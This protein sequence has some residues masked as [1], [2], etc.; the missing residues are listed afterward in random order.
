[1]SVKPSGARDHRIDTLRGL[2]LVSIFINHVPGN[3]LEPLTH[4]NFGLSDSA[5]LFV[6]LAGIAAAFAYLPGFAAGRWLL[7]SLK[8]V[9]RAAVLYVA[10]LA[11]TLVGLGIF[12][13][14][15]LAFGA[16]ELLAMVNI[17]PL[18]D[19]PVAGLAGLA[20]MTHQLGYH[21]ILP[22]YV[23]MLLMLPALLALAVLDLRLML[24]GSI[25]L[26]ALAQVFG[27]TMPSFPNEG[28]W[29]FNPFAWQLIFTIGIFVGARA[30]R[31]ETP[32]AYRPWLW[33]T[34]LA[35][36]AAALVYH[37]WNFYGSIPNLP[38]LP[39]HFQINEKPWVAAPRLAHLL[40]LAYVVGHSPVMRWLHRISPANPLPLLGRH[41][42]P[43]FWFGTALSMIGLIT[44]QIAAPGA[45][46]QVALLSTG[47]S[48]QVAL[49]F[50][51]EWTAAA[52]RRRRLPAAAETTT[53]RPPVGAVP[54]T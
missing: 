9:K 37:R 15:A 21:N 53:A 17:G 16:S 30:M 7:S 22:M 49:A 19:Q 12:C 25:T 2:A 40:A 50:A 29:F 54:V 32:V 1:M 26:Y 38:F 36:L 20:A 6:L 52:E 41:A 24:A 44:M 13:F 46:I 11:S 28:G 33:W 51:L 35:Y 3:V 34:A 43:V 39:V 14:A 10:H 27:W 23:C 4:K 48:L 42:L 47:L 31:G 8:A 45:A 18:L 5:E